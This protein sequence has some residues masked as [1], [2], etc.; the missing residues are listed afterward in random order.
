MASVTTLFLS[1]G[2]SGL[3]RISAES[4]NQQELDASVWRWCSGLSLSVPA[5]LPAL[6][7]TRALLCICLSSTKTYY[8]SNLSLYQTNFP[9]TGCSLLSIHDPTLVAWKIYF[10]ITTANVQALWDWNCLSQQQPILYL[11]CNWPQNHVYTFIEKEERKK[12]LSQSFYH[13]PVIGLSR[14]VFVLVLIVSVFFSFLWLTFLPA[15]FIR[16]IHVD[17]APRSLWVIRGREEFPNFLLICKEIQRKKSLTTA[18]L[19]KANLCTDLIY[20][21]YSCSSGAWVAPSGFL[22]CLVK[23]WK[24][25]K[26]YGKALTPWNFSWKGR[27]TECD[28]K[29]FRIMWNNNICQVKTT[30]LTWSLHVILREVQKFV[31]SIQLFDSNVFP[32]RQQMTSPPFR[33]GLQLARRPHHMLELLLWHQKYVIDNRS[34]VA[35]LNGARL[36]MFEPSSQRNAFEVMTW[37]KRPFPCHNGPVMYGCMN[38]YSRP[39]MWPRSNHEKRWVTSQSSSIPLQ[40]SSDDWSVQVESLAL[41]HKGPIWWPL[42]WVDLHKEHNH[43]SVTLLSLARFFSASVIIYKQLFIPSHWLGRRER[44]YLPAAKLYPSRYFTQVK[45]LVPV[46]AYSFWTF[47][48]GNLLVIEKMLLIAGSSQRYQQRTLSSFTDTLT[49]KW[50]PQWGP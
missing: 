24:M 19:F 21:T 25:Q 37:T 28:L 47:C 20:R 38:L 46:K 45:V 39:G 2:R 44:V 7:H 32:V 1:E 12:A 43:G 13:C 31:T 26:N 33:N 48:F 41:G 30:P 10:I 23:D 11:I 35:A 50:A 4:T 42:W 8:R 15:V 49:S 9:Q 18:G 34:Q 17:R 5:C 22:L 36:C 14:K 3:S 40:A 27:K 29:L 6:G 16:D